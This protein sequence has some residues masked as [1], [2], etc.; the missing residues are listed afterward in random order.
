MAPD[1]TAADAHM[2]REKEAK[3]PLFMMARDQENVSEKVR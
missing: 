3:E 1:I 2:S